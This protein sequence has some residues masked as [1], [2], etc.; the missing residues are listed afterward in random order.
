MQPLRPPSAPAPAPAPTPTPTPGAP[1]P[2]PG[3]GAGVKQPRVQGPRVADAV[4]QGDKICSGNRYGR[5]IREIDM[6][7]RTSMRYR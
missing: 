5:S 7:D 1:A 4:D 6:G 2:T 3:A